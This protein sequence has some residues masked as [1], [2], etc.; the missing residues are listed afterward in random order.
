M[1]HRSI[2]MNA[3]LVGKTEGKRSLGMPRRRWDDNIKMDL[4]EI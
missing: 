2:G 4:G 3:V 1:T